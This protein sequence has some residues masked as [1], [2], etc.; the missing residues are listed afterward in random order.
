MYG[1]DSIK[2][3]A[4]LESELFKQ[5][6]RHFNCKLT[7]LSSV[8]VTVVCDTNRQIANRLQEKVRGR[9][10]VVILMKYFF[11]MKLK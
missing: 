1:F 11:F 9:S 7:I 6:T 5:N 10:K 3:N 8:C 4:V 2:R